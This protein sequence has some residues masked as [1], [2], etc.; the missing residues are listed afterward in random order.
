M[1]NQPQG[2]NFDKTFALQLAAAQAL[3]A[4]NLLKFKDADNVGLDDVLGTLFQTG[5]E[6][7]MRYASGVDVAN[8]DQNL[9]VAY[10]ALG[11]YLKQRGVITGD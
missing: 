8:I 5:G 4:A 7:A 9:V 1:A 11:S 6:V 10:E 3:A 2:I